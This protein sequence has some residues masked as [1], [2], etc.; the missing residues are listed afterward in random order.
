MRRVLLASLSFLLLCSLLACSNNN[1][2]IKAIYVAPESEFR[3]ELLA[4]G[5]L[6]GGGFGEYDAYF[7]PLNGGEPFHFEWRYPDKENPAFHTLTLVRD[8]RRHVYEDGYLEDILENTLYALGYDNV[9]TYEAQ[10][11][12]FAIYGAASGPDA[13]VLPGQAK[14]LEV[15]EVELNYRGD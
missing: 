6:E 9:Q 7:L 4:W 1:F 13:A 14:F 2:R 11:G 8:N 12:I 5:N 15:V 3:L 10:E